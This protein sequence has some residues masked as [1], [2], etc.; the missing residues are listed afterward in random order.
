MR[1]NKLP[2][3]KMSMASS[4]AVVCLGVTLG[5]TLLQYRTTAVSPLSD[6]VV[7]AD[8]AVPKR[9]LADVQGE[10]LVVG[11][12]LDYPQDESTWSRTL[13]ANTWYLSPAS[14][15]NRYQ[16]IG[17]TEYNKALC[18]RYLGGTCVEL[19]DRLFERRGETGMLLA[20]EL[21]I[22]NIQILK[23]SFAGNQRPTASNNYVG[24]QD[25]V[26]VRSVPAGWHEV[27]DDGEIALWSR[28]VPTDSS[29]GLVWTSP[30]TKLTETGRTATEVTLRVDQVASG[31][32]RAAL[33]RLP[34]PGYHASGADI[35]SPVDGFLLA[36]DV[37]EHAAGS[38]VSVAFTPPGW[39]AGV[40]L[41]C[42]GVGGMVL[43][44]ACDLVAYRR[45]RG[46]TEKAGL[47]S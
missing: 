19:L 31:G 8:T 36:L 46:S 41:W 32:G 44:T 40:A 13:M 42:V 21:G 26:P 35:T 5:T 10:V 39:A 7:P 11:D 12:P 17:H 34:W 3:D 29:G 43:W 15:L 16:L 23:K 24:R 20:D 38:T 37:P 28:D 45:R 25:P 22:D 33:G 27:S 30:G 2:L 47:A 4:V 18:L 1:G 14:V 6:S 9:V